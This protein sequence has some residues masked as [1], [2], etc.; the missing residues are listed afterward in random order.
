MKYKYVIL[1]V[2][3]YVSFWC[4]IGF[5]RAMPEDTFG[6]SARVADSVLSGGE[7]TVFNQ[8]REAFAKPA[9]NLPTEDLRDFTFGNKMFN[10]KWVTA[11][12]SVTSLDGLGTTFNRMSCAACHFKDGRGRPPSQAGEPMKSMLVRLSV[13][14][15]TPTGEP[16][17]HPV[18]GGQLNDSA[19]HGVPAEGRVEISYEDVPGT[20]ADGAA[21]TLRRPVYVF[22]DMAFGEISP[23]VMFSPRVA[24]AVHG[25]GLLEAIPEQAILSLADP[26][27][28][29]GD[30]ISGRANYVWDAVS[31]T[32]ALG[33]FGWKANVSTL[34]QQDAGAALGDIGITTSLFS[35]QNCPA[36]QKECSAAPNGGSPEMSDE[37]LEKMTFYVST[38]AVPARRDIEDG[39]IVAG[40]RLF[41]KAQCAQC[42]TP[43]IKTG[44]HA[45]AALSG[46][47]I[48]PYSDLL[49]HDMGADLADN[50]PDFEATGQ[51]WRTPP[52][53]GIGLVHV[54]NK[55]TNFL[56]DGRARNIEEAILWHGGEAEQSRDLFKE[57]S[58]EEREAL[59]S[60]L[61][62][63]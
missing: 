19:I 2:F 9:K 7:G 50:R 54:V 44:E 29:D 21:Y 12:A 39:N 32:R 18:Y 3:A 57:M 61:N 42:H 37:Q 14:G 15:E 4:V 49:L 63:L 16:N 35:A 36:A 26:D 34:I 56:H 45:I 38:L 48:Q 20:Y 33:R 1:T 46:Q 17:P 62:S 5:A 52:L 28:L 43:Q 23:D 11:P 58:K 47:M 22:K 24:P 6:I 59:L 8:S 13:A 41:E 10:T 31:K 27:D 51:E 40:A 30:G 53:W 60:F 55:H 25:M